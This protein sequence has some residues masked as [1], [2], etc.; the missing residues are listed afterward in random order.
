MDLLR[1]EGLRRCQDSRALLGYSSYHSEDDSDK[2]SA[3][4]WLGVQGCEMFTAILAQVI[5]TKTR[6][7]QAEV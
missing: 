5:V 7:C 2:D 3:K 6:E 4:R 1:H